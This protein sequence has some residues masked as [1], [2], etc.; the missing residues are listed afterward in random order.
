MRGEK[1]KQFGI[2]RWDIA[3]AVLFIAAAALVW[4]LL[5]R[6][7]AAGSSVEIKRNGDVIGVYDLSADREFTVEDGGHENTIVISGGTVSVREANCPDQY[8]VKHAAIRYSGECI[9]CL[10]AKLVITITGGEEAPID[11]YTG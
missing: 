8:C 1:K 11:A 6:P 10:P 7:E 2:T 5:L 3:L 4:A 9:V